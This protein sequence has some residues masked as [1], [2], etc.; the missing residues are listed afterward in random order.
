M[1]EETWLDAVPEDIRGSMAK[2][3][4]VGALAKGYMELEAFRG[5]SL[6][7]PGEDASAGDQQAFYDKVME[8]VPGLVRKPQAEDAESYA[9]FWKGMGRP[10]SADDYAALDGMTPDQTQFMR[11]AALKANLTNDQFKEFAGVFAEKQSM[12]GQIASEARK[13]ELDTIYQGLGAGKDQKLQAVK[14]LAMQLEMDESLQDF[15]NPAVLNLML[16]LVDKVGSEGGQLQ[17][18][19]GEQASA[20]MTPAEA[21]LKIGEIMNDPAYMDA[22]DP[23]HKILQRRVVELMAYKNPGAS[24]TMASQRVGHGSL[25][26]STRDTIF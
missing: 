2:F 23:R 26:E 5:K 4:D 20:V 18:Q 15:E 6:T 14:N 8:K 3:D 24:T 1:S 11:D 16:K 22:S 10:E 19:I 25:A 17:E 21:E 7:I 9:N 12:D 13:A